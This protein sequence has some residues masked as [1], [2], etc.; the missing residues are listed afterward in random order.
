[1]SMN[2]LTETSFIDRLKAVSAKRSARLTGSVLALTVTAT[3]CASQEVDT[4]FKDVKV[5]NITSLTVGEDARIRTEPHTT[6]SSEGLGN[7]L[8]KTNS[9]LEVS[10]SPDEE[11]LVDENENGRWFGL[12]AEQFSLDD[13]DGIVWVNKQKVTNVIEDAE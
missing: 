4:P 1:M 5:S 12:P 8:E 9:E 3:G 13:K 7:V 6:S 10:I 11:V 2:H